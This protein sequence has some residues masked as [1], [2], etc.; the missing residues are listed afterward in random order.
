MIEKNLLMM[1]ILEGIEKA[2]GCPLCYLW[3]KKEKEIMSRLLLDEIVVSSKFMDEVL[4]AKGFCNRHMHL[5]YETA[6]NSYT[7]DG[8]TYP[9]YMRVI[10]EK[11]IEQFQSLSPSLL[12]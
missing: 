12:N 9:L 8:L 11:I 4:T 5:L 10:I 3:L 2:K 1:P 7:E 6:Y